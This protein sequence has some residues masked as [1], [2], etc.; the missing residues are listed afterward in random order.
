MSPTI[1][2][3]P[4]ETKSDD[5]A[6]LHRS[7]LAA[8]LDPIDKA[9]IAHG[10]G[11]TADYGM[12]HADRRAAALGSRPA[13][14]VRR[15]LGPRDHPARAADQAGDVQALRSAIPLDGEN[16]QAAA[17]HGSAEGAL[18]RRSPEDEPGDDGTVQKG[19]NQPARRLPADAGPDSGVLR[20]V[21]RAA[22]KRRAAP[23]AVLRLDPESLRTRSVL[24]A[25][26]HQRRRSCSA[27][28]G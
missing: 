5:R 16:A 21:L 2:V 22:R 10:L 4:G 8:Q 15:Q 27:R 14:Q 20:A 19:K 1:T 18:R 17:A 3:A 11:L 26:D 9:G 24:C 12:L 13:A 23:G 28:N 6:S 25:A 7:E